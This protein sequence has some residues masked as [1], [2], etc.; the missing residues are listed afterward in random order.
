MFIVAVVAIAAVAFVGFTFFQS[1]QT[2]GTVSSTDR[3]SVAS[4]GTD[5]VRTEGDIKVLPD[6]TKYLIS[7]SMILSGGPPKGGIGV[8]IG[9]AAI[10]NPK[11]VSVAEADRFLD[12]D[13]VVFGVVIDGEARA[14]TKEVLVFHEIANDMFGD[15]PVL[16]TYCPLCGTA[17]A[18]DP[19]I[20]GEVVRFGTSGKLYNSNLVMYDEKTESYWTQVGGLAVVGELTGTKLNQIPIDTLLYSDWKRLHPDTKVLSRDTGFVRPYGVDPYGGYYTDDSA[21]GFGVTFT[22]TRLP[23]K[24]I[25]AGVVIGDKSKA[26]SVPDVKAAGVVNDEFAGTSLLVTMDP[27]ITIAPEVNPVQIYE[28][29]FEG[30]VLEFEL[31]DGK[32]VD[33]QTGTEWGF[34]TGESD[35]GQLKRVVR[36][37][38]FWFNWVAFHPGTELFVP[39]E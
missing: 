15:Q 32:L 16:V 22:D 17:I 36:E 38:D 11:F 25:I 13:D 35:R 31:A 3:A 33:R 30:Q 8:D 12:D 2:G 1:G 24:Q 29:E 28:R 37:S 20:D 14:Y 39:Q 21:V 5:A 19:T 4:G 10:A 7:P 26:Y 18:F 6:G 9:I 23:A 34:N 27:S